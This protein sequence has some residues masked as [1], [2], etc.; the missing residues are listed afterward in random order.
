M[1]CT[2]EWASALPAII[3]EDKERKRFTVDVNLGGTSQFLSFN[4]MQRTFKHVPWQSK[5]ER[6]TYILQIEI[7]NLKGLSSIYELTINY[8]CPQQEKIE[9]AKPLNSYKY[10]YDENPPVPF[11]YKITPYG[12]VKIRFSTRMEPKSSLNV[13]EMYSHVRKL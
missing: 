5:L 12:E 2:L 1:F 6:E 8:L 10:S 13:K 3:G 7:V 9:K 11:I 4:K